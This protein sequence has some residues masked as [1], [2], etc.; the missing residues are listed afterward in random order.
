MFFGGNNGQ[1]EDKTMNVY[2]EKYDQ[3]ID[4]PFD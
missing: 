4:M 3:Y 2:D 1:E